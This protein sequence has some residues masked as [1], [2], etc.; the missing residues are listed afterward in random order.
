MKTTDANR[1][2]VE[3]RIREAD[4]VLRECRKLKLDPVEVLKH[5]IAQHDAR[6]GTQGQVR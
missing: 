3:E 5:A 1:Q 6:R 2:L 4:R